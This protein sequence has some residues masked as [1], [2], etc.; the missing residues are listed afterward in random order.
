MTPGS[1][2]RSPAARLRALLHVLRDAL[3]GR[4]QD[5]TRGPEGRAVILLAIPMMLEMSM[6]SLFAIVDIAFVASLGA[7]AVAAVGLTEATLTLLYALA[8]GLSVGVTATVARRVGEQDLAGAR[9][10]AGQAVWLGLA[11]AAAIGG[12]GL[13][14]GAD[15]LRL[16]GA[17]DAVVARGSGFTTLMLGGSGTI[18]FLFLLNGVFRGAGDATIAMRSLWLANGVNIVLDPCLIF[19]WGPFPE[20]GV[21]GA[22]VATN[23]GRGTGVAYQVWHLARGRG[24]LHL[25][26]T[27]LVPEPRV[28]ARLVRVSAGGIAQY[29]IATSSWIVLM[30]FVAPFGSAAVAGYTIAIRL[31]DV[32]FLPAWGLG[33]AAATLV[34]QNLGAGQPGRAERS[35]WQAAR[36]NLAFLGVVAL[37]FLLFAPAY[38]GLFTADPVVAAWGVLA[39][40]IIP[41][42]FGF[43]AF[44][45]IV[46]QAFNGAGDTRTPT[47]VNLACFW[48]LQI[49]L[50]WVLTGPA[51]FGP[52]GVFT[53]VVVAES[54]LAI[55]AVVLFRRGGWK[56]Q[57]V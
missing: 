25:R 7:D 6:E 8:V 1:P 55:V 20:L 21:T 54:L 53:A 27:D 22:A 31:I 18:V 3:A 12:V 49:P 45:L 42:G 52:A 19:G 51:G 23:I 38:V 37:S 39:L 16:M 10:A 56:R 13:A 30:R 24:R 34:G 40:R 43:W 26:D 35:V 4:E 46:V 47:L 14:F 2:D 32:F 36:F 50:A 5:Y 41:C 29:L 15:I 17:S 28:L 48:L 44:G 11:I 9:R 33:N 57:V